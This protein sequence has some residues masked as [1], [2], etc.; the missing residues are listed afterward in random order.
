MHLSQSGAYYNRVCSAFRLILSGTGIGNACGKQE[1]GVCL[2]RG[3]GKYYGET[4]VVKIL[5]VVTE[6]GPGGAEK[7]VRELSEHLLRKGHKVSLVSLKAPPEN[8]TLADS[9]PAMGISPAYLNMRGLTDAG[10]IFSLRR[11]IRRERPD[12]IHSHL[13]HPNLLTRIAAAGLSVSLVNTVH[14]CERRKSARPFFLLDRLTFP[15]CSV[16]PAV[17]HSAAGFHEHALGL[18]PG[19]LRVIYN[20]VDPVAPLPEEERVRY[21]ELWGMKQCSRIIG[22]FGRLDPQKGFDNFLRLLPEIS[23]RI[24]EGETWGVVILGEGKE[25]EFLEEAGRNLPGNLRLSFPGFSPEAARAAWVFDVFVMPSRYE[26]YGLAFAEAMS[27]G[28]PAVVASV[29]SLPELAD[30]YDNAFV[31]DF[32]SPEKRGETASLIAAA[33]GKKRI[34][35]KII[36]T[37][38]E[39]ADQYLE[40][41]RRIL[42]RQHTYLQK[43]K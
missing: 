35:P 37:R 20:G 9:F 8:R 5:T 34:A 25:R 12:L 2:R 27:T 15:L 23:E 43:N 40:L 14:I 4:L 24:P 32:A 42:A 19:T 17:S 28:V 39:M 22:S 41:Y 38:A 21:R 13:M 31:A 16:C 10:K 6:L 26:G 29:D 18:N 7:I 36:L 3:R 11:I 33:A 30:L 1:E